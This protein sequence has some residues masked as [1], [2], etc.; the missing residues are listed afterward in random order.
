MTEFDKPVQR[1]TRGAYSVLY[2]K[3]EKIVV[4]LA[5]GDLIEF[6]ARGRRHK[7]TLNADVGFKYAVRLKAFADA[8]EKRRRKKGGEA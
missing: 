1:R 4:R 5:P 7:W 2:R 8:A 3:A 6:R